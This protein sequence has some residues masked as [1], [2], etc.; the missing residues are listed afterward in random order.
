MVAYN[1]ELGARF[2]LN[3]PGRMSGTALGK[4]LGAKSFAAQQITVDF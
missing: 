1:H 4:V 3:I 2:S